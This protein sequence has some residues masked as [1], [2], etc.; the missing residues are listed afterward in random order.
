MSLDQLAAKPI[1]QFLA[2]YQRITRARSTPIRPCMVKAR[3][4][5]VEPP[6]PH[7]LGDKVAAILAAV[8]D[9]SRI[10][11]N[12]ILGPKRDRYCANPRFV[13]IW[14][15]RDLTRLSTN[16]IGLRFNRDHSSILHALDRVNANPQEFEPILSRA[17]AK[18]GL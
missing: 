8:S 14:L 3:Q 2:D 7:F 13:A 12:E 17:K 10:S 5:P 6:P 15:A 9:A 18:L 16:G 11:I 4:K 1:A